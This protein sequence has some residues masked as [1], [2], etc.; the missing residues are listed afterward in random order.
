MFKLN[1]FVYKSMEEKSVPLMLM[2]MFPFIRR[3]KL[4]RPP[5]RNAIISVIG[6]IVGI[7]AKSKS[8][9]VLV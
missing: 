1:L 6:E 5:T 7:H 8:L 4:T 9:A 2:C 3:W